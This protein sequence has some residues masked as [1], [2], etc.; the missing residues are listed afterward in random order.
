M[1]SIFYFLIFAEPVKL[2]NCR[3]LL[4]K[5]NIKYDTAACIPYKLFAQYLG[6]HGKGGVDCTYL[7]QTLLIELLN[8]TKLFVSYVGNHKFNQRSL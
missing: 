8:D 4:G 2:P 7:Q 1:C 3:E 6:A 5:N